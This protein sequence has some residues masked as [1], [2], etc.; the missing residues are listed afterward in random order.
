[1]ADEDV[2]LDE[3]ISAL[4]AIRLDEALGRFMDVYSNQLIFGKPHLLDVD[5][6]VAHVPHETFVICNKVANWLCGDV[7]GTMEIPADG[8]GLKRI[9]FVQPEAVAA[10]NE[11]GV[12]IIVEYRTN[13]SGEPDVFIDVGNFIIG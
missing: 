7:L 8:G 3:I 13:M 1:M 4:R 12:R 10:L 2:S 9:Y 5:R 6:L 11:I